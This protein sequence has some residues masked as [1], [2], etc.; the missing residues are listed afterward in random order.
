MARR[1]APSRRTRSDSAFLHP[2]EASAQALDNL[3][4]LY[5]R[6]MGELAQMAERTEAAVGLKPL[7]EPAVK[8]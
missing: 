8:P 2:I 1:T 3:D 4:V 7:G 6:V 5:L